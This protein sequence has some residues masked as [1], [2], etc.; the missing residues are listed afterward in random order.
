[1]APMFRILDRYVLRELAAPFVIGLTL[2]TFFLVVDRIYQ[3]TDLVVN[4]GVPLRLVLALVA[5]MLPSFLTLAVPMAFLVATLLACGRLAGDLE[6]VALKAS[7]VGPLRLLRPFLAAGCAVTLGAALLTLVIAPW[8][9]GAFQRYLFTILQTRAISGIKERAFNATFPQ[10]MIYVDAISPSEVALSGLLVSDERDPNVSR[11][12]TAR[13]GRL[14]TDE[15]QRRV[16]IRFLDGALSEVD[17][18]DA[19]RFRQTRFSLYDMTV[20]LDSGIAA[21]SGVGKP[22]RGLPVGALITRTRDE[23]LDRDTAAAF[24]VELQKRFALPVA[25]LVFLLVGFPLGIA[26]QRGG[27]GAALALSLVVV[28][29]YYVLF[30]F[31]ENVALRGR[32]SAPVA[33]WTP[34]AVF[35]LIGLALLRVDRWRLPPAVSRMFWRF[36][37]LPAW[38][39]RGGRPGGPPAVPAPPRIRRPRASTFITD[40][41]V[42]RQYSALLALGLGVTIVLVLVVN[43]LQV[44]DRVLRLKPPMLSILEHFLLR[45]PTMIYQGLP[46]VVLVATLFLFMSLARYRELDALQAAGVSLFRTSLPVLVLGVGISLAAVVFQETLL[47]AISAQAE[48]VDFVKIRGELPRH[49]R[50]QSRLWYRGADGRFFRI[51]L[52]DPQ[53]RILSGLTVL[54]LDPGFQGARRVDARQAHWTGS[55][56]ELFD[57]AVRDLRGPGLP[58]SVL[59]PRAPLAIPETLEDFVRLQRPPDS[60]SFLELYDYVTRLRESGHRV[61]R[62]VVDM[63]A[64]LAFPLVNAITALVA[65]PFALVAAR[66]GG[67]AVG[68]AA[69]VVITVGYWVVHSMALAFAKADLLPP[70]MAAWTAN[71]VFLGV[72]TAL[73]LRAPT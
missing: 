62:Y 15:S 69:A 64:R 59:V 38:S 45:L 30:V 48:E 47:P 63:H 23:S 51:E 31:L 19:R 29:S 55:G 52:M 16:T 65:I 72:G 42:L 53:N 73:F 49:L 11:I 46:I 60:M 14:L 20:P 27:R 32:L 24:A 7:G 12:V 6:V 28:A 41:Y 1:M 21:S 70:L 35:T 37:S 58:R 25:C 39:R 61:G 2:F 34:S 40:R 10:F 17:R 8:A 57:A 36:V 26:A 56:W 9:N 66:S 71:I 5:L 44:L 43:L 4:K 18:G 13:E 68:V 22:E 33:I 54:E 67:R 3:L 50:Q